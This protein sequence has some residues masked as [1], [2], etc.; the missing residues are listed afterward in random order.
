MK[1]THLITRL[2]I[3]GAQENT[4]LTCRGLV[5]LGHDVTL[6][7]GPETGAEGS[8]WNQAKDSGAKLTTASHVQR[9][10]NPWHD[11]L[12]IAELTGI[13]REISPDVVH[14]H[15]SKAGILGR[16]AAHR[17][18]VPIII[19]TIHGMS[20]NRTQGAISHWMYRSLE[21]FVAKY[22]TMFVTVA[23]AMIEQSVEAGIGPRERFITIR[24]GMEAEHFTPD[25][26]A[27]LRWRQKWGLTNEH[28]VVGT[29]A[30]LF[31]NK[32]YDEIIAAMPAI[33]ARAPYVRFVWIGEGKHRHL[34]EERLKR[35][36]LHD[37]VV[38]GGLIPPNQVGEMIN[39]F[40]MMAHA[41]RWEGLPRALVQGLLLEKPGVSFDN[42]GAPE[43]IQAGVTGLLAPM[44][45]IGAFADLIVRLGA[46]AELRLKMGNEGR[47][48]CLQQ[49]EW[50]Q[51]ARNMADLYER[52][53]KK[54]QVNC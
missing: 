4:V 48:I 44:G 52:L 24:S 5:E 45:D 16:L 26:V 10:V 46:D 1:I 42:D 28:V 40:D 21:R 11:T 29:V 30:R 8:L 27:R 37:R 31:E 38:F 12:A 36:G 7:A 49:F 43:V 32:G 34:Y 54:G 51:L 6:V 18:Q 15:S 25:P 41:S 3:G 19:H 17:A 35:L 53:A 14:T 9:A 20:F 13:F 39:G 47:K 50:R 33:V 2:I 22:T 23:D